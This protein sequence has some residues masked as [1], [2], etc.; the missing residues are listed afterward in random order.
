MLGISIVMSE[1]N[2]SK[3][4]ALVGEG[5]GG[6]LAGTICAY[7]PETIEVEFGEEVNS[8]FS[9]G[10]V[11]SVTIDRG[12]RLANF[13]AM[14]VARKEIERG[15]RFTLR[16]AEPAV[17]A[18]LG[19]RDLRSHQRVRPSDRQPIDV[20]I[21]LGSMEPL[22]RGTLIDLST[23]GIAIEVSTEDEA[24][25]IDADPI[26]VRFEFPGESRPLLLVGKIRNR[27][28]L[29]N[30]VKYGIEFDAVASRRF[31]QQRGRIQ[32][33]ICQRQLEDLQA[34]RAALDEIS[35]SAEIAGPP[36]ANEKDHDEAA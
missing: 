3:L 24:R 28:L 29:D 19:A 10:S 35:R 30:G 27:R 18:F 13:S 32:R 4:Q 2:Q 9:L 14:V 16:V 25:V 12:G 15:R 1:S 33:Y 8:S 26:S 20:H 21:H 36:L 31:P 22:V 7:T 23:T 11:V 6:P 17:L 34:A 5:G